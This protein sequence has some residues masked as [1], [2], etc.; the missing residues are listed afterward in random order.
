MHQTTVRFGS[1]LWGEIG[2]AAAANG[3][4]VAQYV[5]EAALARL[6]YSAAVRGDQEYAMALDIAA[7]DADES[8][9]GEIH[10]TAS[11]LTGTRPIGAAHAMELAEA[12]A[13]SASAL[14]AQGRQ[15]RLRARQLREEITQRRAQRD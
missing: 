10:A 9:G 13:H 1:E 7:E 14:W 3:V 11:S 4:S 6:I 5:R 15:A 12:E 8:G 2:R